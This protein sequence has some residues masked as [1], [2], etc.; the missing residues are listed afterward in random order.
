MT[1]YADYGGRGIK[2]CQRWDSYE[3]FL[4][5]KGE[6]PAE[7]GYELDRIGVNGDYTPENTRWI[8]RGTGQKRNT[9]FVQLNGKSV[10]LARAAHELG[11]DY[12]ALYRRHFRQRIPFSQAVAELQN[13]G[14]A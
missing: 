1:Q 7:T 10:T 8:K 6:I 11:L 2:V 3:N 4:A 14:L 5:D 9:V 12:F 13:N